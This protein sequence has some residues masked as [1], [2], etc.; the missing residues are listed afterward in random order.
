[1]GSTRRKFLAAAAIAVFGLCGGL[2]PAAALSPHPA[3]RGVISI[4]VWVEL[5]IDPELR[6]LVDL[7]GI[8]GGVADIVTSRM[9]TRRPNLP[10]TVAG[11]PGTT[12]VVPDDLD[13]RQL[14][15]VLTL[16]LR[17]SPVGADGQSCCLGALSIRFERNEPQWTEAENSLVLARGEPFLAGG[18]QQTIRERTLTLARGLMESALDFL[19]FT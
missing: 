15:M 13:A 18:D 8:R 11:G 4:L 6:S 17:R 5:N 14:V 12:F 9:Q 1:M 2:H 3:L 10:V 16:T 19:Q 7:Q